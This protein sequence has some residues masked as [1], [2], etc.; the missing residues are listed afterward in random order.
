MKRFA[1][2]LLV[3]LLALAG[4]AFCGCA[5]D[6]LS[7]GLE[8]LPA[9]LDPQIEVSAQYRTLFSCLFDPL[10]GRGDDG[11]FY[12]LA[13]EQYFFSADGGELT[14]VVRTGL[15]WSDGTALT[16]ADFAFALRRLLAPETKS[17]YAEL[18]Y[19]IDGARDYHEGL[20]GHLSG[21]VCRDSYT[22]LLRLTD[23][24]D[25]DSLLA[26]FAETF[27]APCNEA[28]FLSTNGAYGLTAS[29]TLAA[30]RYRAVSLRSEQIALALRSTCTRK[31]P[32]KI[33]F[34]NASGLTGAA[35]TARLEA[36]TADLILSHTAPADSALLTVTGCSDSVWTVCIGLGNEVVNA[37]QDNFA[38]ALF[39][40]GLAQLQTENDAGT[41]IPG[42][43]LDYYCGTDVAYYRT[44][45]LSN[46]RIC[47]RNTLV[48]SG[49][50]TLPQ[51]VLL[52]PDEDGARALSDQL[53]EL[54][55]KN[56]GLFISR[57]YVTRS[58]L[59]ALMRAGNYDLALTSFSYPAATPAAYYAQVTAAVG[60]SDARPAAALPDASALSA[61]DY[62]AAAEEALRADW[63]ILPFAGAQLYFCRADNPN[64]AVSERFGTASIVE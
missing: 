14:F 23:D 9:S 53:I 41:V 64:I 26:C 10:L 30:G 34:F 28:F 58:R 12:G 62:V 57:E 31:L 2:L 6:D 48:L 56:L 33:T 36:G 25:P 29:K 3:L 15:S 17:P 21:V 4:T 46:A 11:E 5:P 13:A 7:I 19:A 22:L 20:V 52:V 24:G 45:S 50:S 27:L 32:E 60:A 55:Q 59:A 40:G 49:R 1:C 43:Y 63:R 47:L 18:L 44:Q 16:A 51:L 61:A 39:Y 35:I 42:H 38:K 8:A 54:W 37:S